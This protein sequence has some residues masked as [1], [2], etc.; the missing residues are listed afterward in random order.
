M[1]A[2]AEN[3]AAAGKCTATVILYI[4]EIAGLDGKCRDLLGKRG[5]SQEGRQKKRATKIRSGDSN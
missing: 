5:L 4:P 3:S 2:E 1:T